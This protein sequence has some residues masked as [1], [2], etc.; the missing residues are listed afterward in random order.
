MTLYADYEFYTTAYGGA[1]E[2]GDFQRL[3]VRASTFL[4]YFTQ[5]RVK[6]HAELDAVKM[7]CCA[8]VDRY[9]LIEDA[10]ALSQKNLAAGLS[11]DAGELQSESD[12]G[13][14]RSFRSSGDSSL[15]ALKTAEEARSGL[16]A[17]AREH[18]ATTG[19]LYRG[20]CF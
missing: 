6:D 5:N 16:A 9:K 1:A 19:L 14:S 20:R 3:C 7:A 4:D 8:L 10:Q 12:G 17:V 15:A 2:F 18:L 11:S 13:Y